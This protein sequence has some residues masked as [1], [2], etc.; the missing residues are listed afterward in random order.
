MKKAKTKTIKKRTATA[1]AKAFGRKAKRTNELAFVTAYKD[2]KE[3]KRIKS[4]KQYLKEAAKRVW[5]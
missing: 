2:G 4:P 3:G 5:K 1:S